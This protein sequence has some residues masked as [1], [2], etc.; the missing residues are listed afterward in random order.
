M[1]WLSNLEFLK[2]RK[3]RPAQIM[4]TQVPQNFALGQMHHSMSFQLVVVL[5]HTKQTLLKQCLVSQTALIICKLGVPVATHSCPP[6]AV[7]CP[8]TPMFFTIL[9]AVMLDRGII[10]ASFYEGTFSNRWVPTGKTLKPDG[11][12]YLNFQEINSRL[13]GKLQ[14]S[15]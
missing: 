13:S 9:A 8:T 11:I 4:A 10:K 3:L 5:G 14:G 7:I 15:F 1:P 6:S 12:S 2:H